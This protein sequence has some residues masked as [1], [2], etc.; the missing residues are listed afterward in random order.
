MT[1]GLRVAAECSRTGRDSELRF[2]FSR[3]G[4]SLTNFVKNFPGFPESWI[5]NPWARQAKGEPGLLCVKAPDGRNQCQ[6]QHV[7]QRSVLKSICSREH[8]VN[9]NESSIRRRFVPRL[10]QLSIAPTTTGG[11]MD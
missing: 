4:E 9:H 10:F 3:L 7:V 1:R 11:A 5:R 8:T 6:I 2:S